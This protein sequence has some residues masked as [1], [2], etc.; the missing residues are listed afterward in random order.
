VKCQ[1]CNHIS[2]TTDPFLDLSLEL[3]SA[4]S[5]E[6]ALLRFC[7]IE[8]LDAHNQYKCDSCRGVSRAKKQL[9]ILSAPLVLTLQLK[10]FNVFGGKINKQ[11]G[12]LRVGWCG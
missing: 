11:I 10:R 9:K 1:K 5:I 8:Q 6:L 3:T 7:A 2:S 12:I 4:K